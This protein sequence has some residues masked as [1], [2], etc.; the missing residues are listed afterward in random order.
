MPKLTVH[1]GPPAA[2]AIEHL[3]D[4]VHA[5]HALVRR[6]RFINLEWLWQIGD[7]PY[8]LHIRDGL[9]VELVR[10]PVLM[11][12]SVFA[13]RGPV[14]SWERFWAPMPKP[15][16]HDLMAMTKT[17]RASID[18]DLQPLM[19]NLRYFKEVLA[20]PRTMEGH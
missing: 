18:G 16:Y 7:V 14:E 4:E 9:I 20:A 10:G 1:G 6:G 3:A 15:G 2:H 11:R 5:N 12:S 13:I 19:A 8:H 17:G